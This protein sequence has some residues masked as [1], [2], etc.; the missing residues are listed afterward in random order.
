[1]RNSI[2]TGLTSDDFPPQTK[3]ET[4]ETTN[5]TET[6]TENTEKDKEFKEMTDIFGNALTET[7]FTDG[8]FGTIYRSFEFNRKP[9]LLGNSGNDL[10]R[11]TDA[12]GNNVHYTVDENTSR[13]EEVTDRCHNRTAYEYD[14]SGRTTKVTSKNPDGTELS[15]VSYAYDAFDNM[16][17]ITRGDGM[18]YV[19]KYNAF[20]NLESIGING[21]TDG[22]LI[23]Y[24]YKNANGRLKEITYA[25]GDKMKATYNGV[26]QMVAEKWYNSNNTLTA[27]YKYVY[28]GEGNIVRSIDISTDSLH[29]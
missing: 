4:K 19:L 1:M 28:D 24:T 16:T 25:N 21:K 10:I 6:K 5:E 2:E 18:K 17:E 29:L 9:N 12:R 3:E 13:N 20:H 14:A 11:E 8:E 15:H 22:D 27:H 26:G 23:K 7:T